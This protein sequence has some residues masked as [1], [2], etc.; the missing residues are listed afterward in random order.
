MRVTHRIVAAAAGSLMLFGGVTGAAN[1]ATGG[2]A[3]NLQCLSGTTDNSGYGGTCTTT[4]PDKSVA[5]LSN[6]ST[7]SNGDY[8]GVSLHK[9]NLAGKPLS[10]ISQLGYTWAAGPGGSTLTP[11]PTD[12]SLNIG[13]DPTGVGPT[14]EYAFVDAFYCPGTPTSS[15]NVV[16]VIHDP[17]CGI[18]LAGSIFYPNWAAL[19]AANPGATV[20]TDGSPFIIAERVGS[21]PPAVWTIS[22]VNLGKL[23]S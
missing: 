13:I 1:A 12:L 20:G 2:A 7:N 14:S 9:Q 8:S 5:V 16:D 19:V 18:Y 6:T 22:N 23:G 17:N 21:A 4:N 10:N 3:S 15:G 11:T